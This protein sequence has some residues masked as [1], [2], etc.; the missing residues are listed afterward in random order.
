M[1]SRLKALAYGMLGSVED[2]EDVLQE[3]QLRLLQAHP[4]PD[5]EEAYLYRLVSNLSI[6]RLRRLKVARRAYSGPWLPQP[7][8][9]DHVDTVALAQE[10]TIG[11]LHLLEELSPAERVSY[12]LREAFDFSHDDIA[13]VLDISPA[14]ARQRNRRARQ[15]LA[16]KTP[17][18]RLPDEVCK[19]LLEKMVACV[20]LD[21]VDGLVAMLAEDAVAYTDGGGVVSAAI[22]PVVG[23]DRIA[24]VTMHL[25][26][27]VLAGTNPQLT[28]ERINGNWALAVREDGALHSVIF[29]EGTA[30]A[31][32]RVFVVRNPAKLKFL[33]ATG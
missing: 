13:Q 33:T 2:A 1:T 27:R 26:R 16:G 20:A 15:R 12:V 3:A 17:P 4:K 9:A 11:F 24:T 32:E 6:D 23:K 25:A 10:L 30:Q 31:I 19:S 28:F 8:T 29:I 21:D 18:A 5:N 14:N 7:A 22:V